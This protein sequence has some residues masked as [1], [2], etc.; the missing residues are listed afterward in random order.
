MA[1][2][3]DLKEITFSDVVQLCSQARRTAMLVVNCPK[4]GKALGFFY[5]ERGELF[6]AKFEDATGLEAVY[7]ALELK[8]GTFHVVLDVR[9]PE[10]RIFEPI[11]MML[12]EGMRR[13]DEASH[14]S[15]SAELLHSSIPDSVEH[16]IEGDDMA[17][18]E[19][20]GRICPTCGKRYSHGESCPD[21]GA[22][23]VLASATSS[24]LAVDTS[25]PARTVPPPPASTHRA[26]KPRGP[27][28]ALGGG[29]A[30]L[31]VVGGV[32]MLKG[33][34]GGS[35]ERTAPPLVTPAPA[36]TATK[37]EPRAPAPAPTQP[38]A[39]KPAAVAVPPTPAVEPPKEPAPAASP[40]GARGITDKEIVFG[41]AAAFTGPSKE[42]GRQMKIGIETAFNGLNESG[43][44]NG[45]QLHLIALDDGY[46]P[47]R[48]LAAMTELN[49]KDQ[50]FGIVGN[51][52]TP[53]AV[54]AVPYALDHKMLFYGAFTGASLLRRDPPDRY[55]FNY[56]ASYAEET[57]AVV[58]YLVK[59]K[60]IRPE[61]IAVFAQ[62]DAFGDAGF[63][64]VAKAMRTLRGGDAGN[65]LRLGYKRNTVEVT[66]AIN[67]LRAYP[68]NIR[69]VVMVAT[70]RSAAKFIEK[71]RE[72]YPSMIYTN[73]SFVGSTSLAE[74]LNLLGTKYAAGVI[75]TQVV[76][77]VDS[78][79]TAVLKYKQLLGKYFPG[80]NPDYVSLEGYLSASVLAEALRRA[81]QQFDTEKL[82]DILENVHNLDLGIGTTIS[83]GL[84]EH[85]GSH[86]VWGTQLDEHGKY[87]VIDLE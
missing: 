50:V 78:H 75:V 51:V 59:V 68:T 77:P 37:E 6:D 47:S 24:P 23:L 73:V 84:A 62:Q 34:S 30:A 83:F 12:L 4:T 29:L 2:A 44:I 61:Q 69:A 60:R 8:E 46:E 31:V 74:E 35:G 64:G 67:R 56:R 80:E 70:Y 86:K 66:D 9:S 52:G 28:I 20:R 76:P 27:L 11:G 45:R 25:P 17:S 42:L 7:R 22:R 43:G 48:T 18:G 26:L 87:E 81:G 63:A 53:T 16:I 38:P 1:L 21:D 39:P 3:G 71:T 85:Q 5:F 10:R 65:I 36:E 58:N 79:S 19:L 14:L 13:M 40:S 33:G 55:V 57:A 49:E 32:W 82:V 41:M 15:D 54:V 72:T